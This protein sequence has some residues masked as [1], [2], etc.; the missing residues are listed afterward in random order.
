M[1]ME[2]PIPKDA[3]AVSV[4]P[5]GERYKIVEKYD[6]PADIW[7][8]VTSQ[9]EINSQIMAR[10]KKHPPRTAREEGVTTGPLIDKI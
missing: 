10:N 6:I 1:C 7:R 9:E 2:S 8:Y 4:T 5:E 3:R